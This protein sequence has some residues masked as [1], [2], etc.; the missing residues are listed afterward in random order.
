MASAPP[1]ITG[2]ATAGEM[3]TATHGG[4]SNS[5][6]SYAQ[7]WQRC[8]SSGSAC[9]AI[10]TGET[11]RLTADDVGHTLRV[12]EI[13]S[14]SAGAGD[15]ATSAATAVVKADSTGGGG[16]AGGGGTGGGGTGGTGGGGAGGTNGGGGGGTPPAPELVRATT[17]G[18]VV[19]V[20][21]SC[22]AACQVQITITVTETL[23]RGKVIS[24]SRKR[25]LVIGKATATLTAGQRRTVRVSLNKAGR[26]L[27]AGRKRFK[28]RLAVSQA[29]STVSRATL[30][31]R[32]K[33]RK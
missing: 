9:G 19:R 5:P 30:T 14:N 1:A 29:G 8:D 25:K 27:L 4:W 3:L 32:R 33:Q 2:A 22:V 6:T 18:T 23:R 12:R 17:S 13:A 26:K 21:I 20:T 28:A 7:T 11:Y 10:A 31:F 16:G 15:A 24:I